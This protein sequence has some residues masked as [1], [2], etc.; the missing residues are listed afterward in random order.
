MKTRYQIMQMS[1]VKNFFS[2]NV[3]QRWDPSWLVLTYCDGDFG[4]HASKKVRQP[5]LRA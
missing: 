2:K 1:S 4:K 3:D 5:N